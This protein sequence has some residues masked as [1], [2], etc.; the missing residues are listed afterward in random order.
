M[1]ISF[2]MGLAAFLIVAGVSFGALFHIYPTEVSEAH[3]G[4]QIGVVTVLLGWAL[5]VG[6]IVAANA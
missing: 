6:T 2:F 1:F 4:V 3:D 5:L